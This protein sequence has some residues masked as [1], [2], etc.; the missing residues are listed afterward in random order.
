MSSPPWGEEVTASLTDALEEGREG[1]RLLSRAGPE[2]GD[3]LG[4]KMSPGF[5]GVGSGV[6]SPPV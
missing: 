2:A 1:G 4:V 6:G 3:L 5:G